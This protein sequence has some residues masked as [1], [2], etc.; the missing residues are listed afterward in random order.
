M[1]TPST[2]V[3]A[4]AYF[5]FAGL[6]DSCVAWDLGTW[7]PGK[8]RPDPWGWVWGRRHTWAYDC[9]EGVRSEAYSYACQLTLRTMYWNRTIIATSGPAASATTLSCADRM[10]HSCAG[11]DADT[12]REAPDRPDPGEK[13]TLIEVELVVLQSLAPGSGWL[14]ND[15]HALP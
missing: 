10:F 14:V 11:G 15:L 1:I 8:P 6:P 9:G 12:D 4:C 2:C 5:F 7:V 13:S 3:R